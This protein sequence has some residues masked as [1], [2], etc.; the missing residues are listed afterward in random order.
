MYIL[1]KLKEFVLAHRTAFILAALTAIIVASPQV[2]FRLDHRDDGVYQGIELMPDSFWSPRVREAQD[3]NLNFGSMYWKEGKDDPYLFQPLGSIVIAYMGKLFS[4]DINN[5]LLLSRVILPFVTFILIYWFVQ[6]LSGSKAAGVTAAS[7]II[8]ADDIL[9]P[10]GLITFLQGESPV[11]FLVF[12]QPVIPAMVQLPLFAFLISLWLL[13]KRGGW[14]LGFTSTLL[15]GSA[16]YNYFYLWTYLYAFGGLLGIFFLLQKQWKFVY[17]LSAVYGGAVLVAIPYLIN[18]YNVTKHPLYD[19]VSE[20]IGVVHTHAPLWVGTVVFASIILFFV[21]Y[22]KENRESYLFNLALILTPFIT[23]NQ[24]LLT[25]KIMQAGH[26][27]Y[28]FHKPIA[29]ILVVVAIYLYLKKNQLFLYKKALT[30]I[31][32]TLSI[33]VAIFIQYTSYTRDNIYGGSIAVERQ[34]YGPAMRWLSENADKDDVVLGNDE[35]SQ[36]VTIYTPLNVFYHRAVSYSSLRATEERLFDMLFTIYRLSGVNDEKTA[37]EVFY[38]DRERIAFDLYHFY[39]QDEKGSPIGLPKDE[40]ERLLNIY[41]STLELPRAE[42]LREM[43]EKYQ[44]EYIVW[45]KDTNPNW[46]VETLPFVSKVASFGDI[47]IY[48]Y[49]EA[50]KDNIEES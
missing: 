12:G 10:N 36:L 38:K 18:L 31:L 5:T 8:L 42:Y 14:L 11:D 2:A 30:I 7:L 41:N 47:E 44:V 3:G 33:F 27:H 23:L 22:P 6:L 39:Y 29:I 26:Y 43:F 16:F 20:R 34:K 35:V 24:Q 1:S 21:L 40:V 15:L 28:Y 19:V 4:L 32:V 50:D 9:D 46:N 48:E 49:S 13:L 45:D 37:K 25:G 17:K